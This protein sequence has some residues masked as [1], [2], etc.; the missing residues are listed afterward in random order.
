M[1]TLHLRREKK[2]NNDSLIKFSVILPKTVLIGVSCG[3]SFQPWSSNV[4][5]PDYSGVTKSP[6]LL[7]HVERGVTNE[8]GARGDLTVTRVWVGVSHP[9]VTW[10]SEEEVEDDTFMY[11]Q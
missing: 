5:I 11:L 8:T 4:R 2:K 1:T 10:R 6:L 9:V 3:S 7:G